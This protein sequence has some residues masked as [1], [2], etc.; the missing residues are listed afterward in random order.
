MNAIVEPDFVT[1]IGRGFAIL[2]C[3]KRHA[4]LGGVF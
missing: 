4:T 3:F 2:R 1:A